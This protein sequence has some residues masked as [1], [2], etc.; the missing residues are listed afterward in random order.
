M[1]EDGG[2][3]E[4]GAEDAGDWLIFFSNRICWIFWALTALTVGRTVW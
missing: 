4:D 2:G 3:A 1:G